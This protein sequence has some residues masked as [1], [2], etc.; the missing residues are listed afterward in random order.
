MS[1][2]PYHRPLRRSLTTLA[3]V[4]AVLTSVPASSQPAAALA[5]T[6]ATTPGLL[7]AHQ[8]RILDTRNGTGG[9]TTPM[10]A[11]VARTLTVTGAAGVPTSGVTAVAVTV[12]AV[13]ATANGNIQIAAGDATTFTGTALVYNTGDTT[14]NTALVGLDANGRLK[15]ASDH[16]GVNV[17]L[18]LQG[19]FTS[20]ADASAGGF[21]ASTATRV[22]DTRTGLG[23]VAAKIPTGSAVTVTPGARIDIPASATAVYASIV[24]VNQAGNGYVTAYPTG[25]TPPSP[26]SLNF[27][28]AAP[29]AIGTSIPLNSDGQFDIYVAAGGPIDVI[30]D[31]EGYFQTGDNTAAFTPMQSRLYDSRVS[32]HVALAA[33]ESRTITVAGT[34][35][36]P[37]M[38]AG[39]DAVAIN[40]T[41]VNTTATA[42][43]Y[44][45]AWTTGQAEPAVSST[46][47]S[48]TNSLRSSLLVL[49][50]NPAGQ[51]TLHNHSNGTIH[52]ILDAEGW[53][54]T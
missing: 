41:T 19:Y 28:T 10:T 27:D 50:P 46:N 9:Y 53:I 40:L 54:H 1:R 35:G 43:G 15:V 3:V 49:A 24:I 25:S 37:A 8:A 23:T 4:C 51:I 18:D 32:P 17:V 45:T 11:N 6:T 36:I 47:F 22:I 26:Y 44:L 38:S 52:F 29:H 2:R 7:V 48:T 30:V 31:I 20:A 34:A 5:D 39:V 13:G 16:S 21:V 33:G 42:I 14:S 12:T